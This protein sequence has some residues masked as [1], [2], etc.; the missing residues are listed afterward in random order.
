MNLDSFIGGFVVVKANYVKK[1]DTLG[2]AINNFPEIAPVL[3][4][5]G[6]HCIGCHVSGYESIE[7]GCLSHGMSTKD[8]T[9]LIN[10]ANARIS[11]FE[12]MPIVTFTVSAA[13]ELNKRL[14]NK[15]FV[16]ITQ[17]FGGEFDFEATNEKEKGDVLVP[18]TFEKKRITVLAGKKIERMLHGIGI[19]YDSK[20]KDFVAKR[21]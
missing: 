21:G 16:K 15:K 6:L 13:K 18:V 9:A 1:T 17:V 4:Q 10:Q 3:A 14:G 11:E 20:Q 12:K 2:E 5:A 19:D 8:V 7:Q